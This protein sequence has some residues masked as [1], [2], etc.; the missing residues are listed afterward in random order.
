MKVLLTNHRSLLSFR[1]QLL[2]RKLAFASFPAQTTNP[3]RI[4]IEQAR[5]MG[6]FVSTGAYPIEFF[7]DIIQRAPLARMIGQPI[8][9]LDVGCGTGTLVSQ[10]RQLGVNAYGI[11][12]DTSNKFPQLRES[13]FIKMLFQDFSPE[14]ARLITGDLPFDHIF[15]AF[16]MFTHPETE[17]FRIATLNLMSDLLKPGG[18]IRLGGIGIRNAIDLMDVDGQKGFLR[19]VPEMLGAISLFP[20]PVIDD[21]ISVMIQKGVEVE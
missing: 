6:E 10:F 3:K 16:T 20:Q 18:D 14:R 9:I 19:A 1:S 12:P 15:S 13:P 4:E 5:S 7:S 2:K 8:K 11:D 21:F 17:E